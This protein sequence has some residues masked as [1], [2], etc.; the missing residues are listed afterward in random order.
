MWWPEGYFIPPWGGPPW[1]WV[2]SRAADRVMG[3]R[4]SQILGQGV[5]LSIVPDA[6]F[7]R[8]N[9]GKNGDVDWLAAAGE[10]IAACYSAGERPAPPGFKVRGPG[11]PRKD[12]VDGKA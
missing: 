10:I 6:N 5:I 8:G 11:R 2:Y 3:L 7:W 1:L 9:F 12:G 4:P